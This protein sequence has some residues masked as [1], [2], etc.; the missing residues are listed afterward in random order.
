MFGLV[1]GRGGKPAA[2]SSLE[3]LRGIK[4]FVPCLWG[5]WRDNP[6]LE[7]LHITVFI[8]DSLHS[9]CLLVL[10]ASCIS[11]SIFMRLFFSVLLTEQLH[12]YHRQ[13]D[14]GLSA[15]SC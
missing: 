1:R 15:E 13:D 11:A 6:V 3:E 5:T 7:V 14:A 8:L 10:F 9:I 4:G 2:A 12:F